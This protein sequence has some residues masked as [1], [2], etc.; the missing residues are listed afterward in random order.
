MLSD[1]SRVTPYRIELLKPFDVAREKIVAGWLRIVF[2]SAI[3]FNHTISIPYQFLDERIFVA[4]ILALRDFGAIGFFVLAGV[5]LKGKMVASPNVRIGMP[6]NLL[7]L[8]IA[9][10]AL[11]LFDMAYNSAKGTYVGSF[12]I[13]FYRALYD[14]NLWFFVAYAFAGPLLLSL[15]G[16]GT[17]WT[18]ICCLFFITFPAQLPLLSPYILQTISLAFVCM[19][20]GSVL[21]GRQASPMLVFL[22]AAVAYLVRVQLDDFGYPVYPAIDVLLRIGYGTACF[23][24]FKSAAD[25]LSRRVAAPKWSNNLFVPYVIQFPLI[26]VVTVL[27]TA[28]FTWSTDVRMPPIFFSFW[29]TLVFMLTIFVVSMAASFILAWLLRRYDIRV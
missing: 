21:Y 29:D 16:R 4:W 7:K 15:D 3:L 5:A 6:S 8:A 10:A 12:D 9:A 20:I 22:I 19:A 13:H 26:V 2:F 18:A 25:V 24:L 17:F 11:A 23:L 1:T 14:T 28:L 27:C